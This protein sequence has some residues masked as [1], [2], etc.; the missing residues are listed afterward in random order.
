MSENWDRIVTVWG[1]PI[2]VEEVIE[3]LGKTVG[4][5]LAVKELEDRLA[6]SER[7][8]LDLYD[9]GCKES[10]RADRAEAKLKLVERV[11]DDWLSEQSGN[12]E[13]RERFYYTL[14]LELPEWLDKWTDEYIEK[15][16]YYFKRWLDEEKEKLGIMEEKQ[17]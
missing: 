6:K 4:L 10:E 17:E 15:H 9:A 16:Q 11:V 5:E 3:F 12:A 2:T 14:G 7:Q 1:R 13:W 8:G